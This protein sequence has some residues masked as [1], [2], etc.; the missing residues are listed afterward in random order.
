MPRTLSFVKDLSTIIRSTVPQEQL[1]G[2]GTITVLSKASTLN[3][4]VV[5]GYASPQ[6]LDKEKH[7]ITRRALAEDLPR[8]LAHPHFRNVHLLHSNIQVGEVL[9][10][11]TDPKT[12]KHYTTHVDK[13]GLFVVVKI[14]TDPYRPSI[15]DK[16]I[17]DI[18]EG[19]L[20]M[21]SISAD[22]PLEARKHECSNGVCFWAIDKI[23]YYE[24]T[25][26]SQGVNPDA[27][28][29]ILSKSDPVEQIYLNQAYCL[30]GSCALPDYEISRLVK[31][32]LDAETE[33][34]LSP[35]KELRQQVLRHK[36]Q[37]ANDQT[38]Q[39]SS[40][41]QIFTSNE[42]ITEK[43]RQVHDRPRPA[44]HVSTPVQQHPGVLNMAANVAPHVQSFID[45]NVGKTVPPPNSVLPETVYD[46]LAENY[47]PS[48]L[49]WAKKA[50]WSFH[51]H[52]SLSDINMS[53]RPGG[54]DGDKTEAIADA[55]KSGKKMDPIVL[56][57]R[58][59]GSYA[60]ADGYH[61]TKAY[62]RLGKDSISAYVAEDVGDHGP[63]DEAMH[64]AKL[65]KAGYDQ[66]N[67]EED[68][69][70]YL[71]KGRARKLQKDNEANSKPALRTGAVIEGTD[72]PTPKTIS[73]PVK[74][75]RLQGPIT[76]SPV[77]MKTVVKLL[78]KAATDL[79]ELNA[80]DLVTRINRGELVALE[81][82]PQQHWILDG[83]PLSSYFRQ[84]RKAATDHCEFELANESGLLASRLDRALPLDTQ[85]A[86]SVADHLSD[87][88]FALGFA[89]PDYAPAT[90]NKANKVPGSK[91]R[92][93][94]DDPQQL[95]PT[96]NLKKL[97][98]GLKN[99]LTDPS[100]RAA[101]DTRTLAALDILMEDAGYALDGLQLGLTIGLS[102]SGMSSSGSGDSSSE[103]GPGDPTSQGIETRI[104]QQSGADSTLD[105][106]AR[107][108]EL[109]RAT[110][111]QKT[112]LYSKGDVGYSRS[113]DKSTCSNCDHFL[114]VG[115]N[116][117]LVQGPIHSDGWCK[118]WT[119]DE[120]LDTDEEPEE[121]TVEIISEELEDPTSLNRASESKQETVEP[122]AED[123]K[124]WA[125][126][127]GSDE[128]VP[129]KNLKFKAGETPIASRTD[130]ARKD[131]LTLSRSTV[132]KAN[133]GAEAV[134]PDRPEH[135]GAM[136]C[137][138]PQSG[139]AQN[140]ADDVEG[141]K[142]QDI[143]LTVVY[144][145][146]DAK[147]IESKRDTIEK[148]LHAHTMIQPPIQGVV[149]GMARFNPTKTSDGK[150]PFVALVDAPGLSKFRTT[151]VDALEEAGIEIPKDHDFTP[152]LT[153]RYDPP[154]MS[155]MHERGI[156]II[157]DMPMT[158]DRLHLVWAGDRKEFSMERG[159]G[160]ISPFSPETI[161]EKMETSTA[162]AGD[163]DALT[164]AN[165]FRKMWGRSF[166][167]DRYQLVVLKKNEDG[168][169]AVLTS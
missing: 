108:D 96:E 13:V 59:D 55:I 107:A 40:T 37:R 23:E 63:W 61:R 83:I 1:P 18:L 46:Y 3:P 169:E 139:L 9:P 22:A 4:L 115:T 119:A 125:V 47:P 95:D 92:M 19:K 159:A 155:D 164:Y 85:T 32:S 128:D 121:A 89:L 26:C 69:E 150:V 39:M 2:Y 112:I 66:P 162:K 90:L 167:D 117:E 77:I 67:T 106:V 151:L 49:G 100:T 62:E 57:K 38:G 149:S 111:I 70:Y 124:D 118:L 33:D 52:V 76:G 56:V 7:L 160:Q 168:S 103:A 166:N 44:F 153:L 156:P 130:K 10:S 135:P 141:D 75:A 11:W 48:V 12:G 31:A 143:H 123:E 79:C 109:L 116:C 14:R 127:T 30:D 50:S 24:V 137:W 136:I 54:R 5:A 42:S 142:E 152:H 148:I 58:S 146:E 131:R 105:D 60:I 36:T 74:V 126:V 28:F 80:C 104:I 25:I 97:H 145:G 65:N 21:F 129:V 43:P 86:L 101:L 72:D 16:V 53:R 99:S 93:S 158:I 51:P 17:K 98:R 87:R 154:G 120:E 133:F 91:I 138:Y 134:R 27:N 41:G 144:L 73:E 102:D 64:D 88:L 6:V 161:R 15:V 34:L 82:D 20:A 163:M 122:A 132:V 68:E 35:N 165:L 140:L 157:Q 94:P 29:T 113:I 147:K 110:G 8:F 84:L 114:G 81:F 71:N 78:A 45:R